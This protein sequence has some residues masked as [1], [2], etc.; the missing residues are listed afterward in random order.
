VLL[1]QPGDHDLGDDLGPRLV[2]RA[3][4][5]AAEEVVFVDRLRSSETIG[6]NCKLDGLE[7]GRLPDIIVA[8]EDGRTVKVQVGKSYAA[9]VLYLDAN[10]AHKAPRILTVSTPD[11]KIAPLVKIVRWLQLR[12]AGLAETS[13]VRDM[14]KPDFRV[15]RW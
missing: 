4:I 15:Q 11:A 10:D 12:L 3:A 5:L 2:F 6:S 8:K 7:D 1:I 14:S 9:K 13:P